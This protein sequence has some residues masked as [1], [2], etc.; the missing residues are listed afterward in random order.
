MSTRS[1]IIFYNILDAL[2]FIMGVC[3]G[4]FALGHV[5]DWYFFA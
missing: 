1:H 5:M 2:A 3:F 4:A